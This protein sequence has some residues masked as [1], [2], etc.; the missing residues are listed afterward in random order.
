MAKTPHIW[1]F[2]DEEELRGCYRPSGQPGVSVPL[3]PHKP[4]G[5]LIHFLLAVV[6]RW[7]FLRLKI[8]LQAAG[9]LP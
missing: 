6:W 3:S 2:D 1:G 4:H 7:K 9:K 8:L 5:L